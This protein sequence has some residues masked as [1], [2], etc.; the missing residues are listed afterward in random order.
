MQDV[1]AGDEPRDQSAQ[2]DQRI[3]A[4]RV[5]GIPASC[6]ITCTSWTAGAA[7]VRS[8][9]DTGGARRRGGDGRRCSRRGAT[10][11]EFRLKVV[12]VA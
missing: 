5:T 12:D 9:R 8:A 11:K 6:I 3:M 4:S 2:A 1:N 10:D 7:S